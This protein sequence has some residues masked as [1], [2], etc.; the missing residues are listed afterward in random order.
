MAQLVGILANLTD[1]VAAFIPNLIS[2][3]VLLAIG[4]VLGKV[5]GRIVKEVLEKI[6]L[7]YYVTETEKPSISI[8]GLFS[9][10]TRWW[11]YLAFITAALSK[12]VLGIPEL[13][14]WVGN[15]TNFVPNI[16]GA[17]IVVVVGY[18]LSEFMRGQLKKTGKIYASI[19]AK[20]LFFFVM[21]VSIAIA[22]QILG[23]STVLVNSILLVIV[24]SFGLGVAIAL[25]LGLK[26]AVTDISKRWVKK[27]KI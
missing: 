11:I 24:A 21:Y 25:G 1:A 13:A 22:L 6:K 8:S 26:D 20:I 15:V 9:M 2:A 5:F 4:L 18:I 3:I 12:E 17:A 10:V 19:V 16:I 14:S 23:L 27:V 7:D